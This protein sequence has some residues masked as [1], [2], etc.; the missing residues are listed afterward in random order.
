M[1]FINKLDKTI[2]Y[3]DKMYMILTSFPTEMKKIF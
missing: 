2:K 1:N 3:I